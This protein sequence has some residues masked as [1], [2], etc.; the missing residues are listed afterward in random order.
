MFSAGQGSYRTAKIDRAL[1]PQV[2]HGLLFTD[3]L[4]EDAD[5]YR[6]LIEAAADV[7]DRPPPNWL[8]HAEDFPD[9]R[10]DE[11]VRIED[12]AGNPE[13]RAFLQQ[14]RERTAEVI[15]EL[16]W[17][18]EGRDP[19]EVFRD[20][21]MLGNTRRDP[22]SKFGKREILDRWRKEHCS[23]DDVFL[24]GIGDHEKERFYGDPAKGTAGIRARHA[25]KGWKVEAPL[26]ALDEHPNWRDLPPGT[27]ALAYLPLEELGMRPPRLYAKGYMHNNCGGFCV[28]AG[29]AHWQNRYRVDPE[30]FAYD[31]MMEQ[32]IRAFLNKNVSILR[33]RRGGKTKPMTLD[34][35]AARGSGP[36]IE[37]L[38]GESGCGCMGL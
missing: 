1:H 5:A 35:F 7:Y 32:K 38:P 17:I 4:Y 25:S 13:W 6:F 11:S 29:M 20:E 21:R 18:V 10:V 36:T 33:D 16:V 34:T 8:P 2:E 24:V 22:C 19:W 14:L 30:R 26:I 12:Y 31:A 28:K 3:V 27:M 37:Y 15:P 23:P 9:Y